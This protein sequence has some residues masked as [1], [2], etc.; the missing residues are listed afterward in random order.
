MLGYYL[1]LKVDNIEAYILPGILI[2]ILLS[3]SPYIKQFLTNAELRHQTYEFV[4]NVLK[5]VIPKK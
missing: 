3:I 4:K 2:I 1:G 5:R